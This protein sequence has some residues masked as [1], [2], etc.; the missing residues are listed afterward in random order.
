MLSK[1]AISDLKFQ[2][3]GLQIHSV[4]AV[5]VVVVVVG[6]GGRRTSAKSS[7][8]TDRQPMSISVSWKRLLRRG[9]M[10]TSA[11]WRSKTLA[12]GSSPRYVAAQKRGV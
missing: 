11:V 2:I 8:Q 12:L 6:G 9:T 5:V 4:G 3:S 10:A 7:C 1:S